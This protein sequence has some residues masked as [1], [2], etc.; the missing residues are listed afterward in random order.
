MRVQNGT[1]GMKTQTPGVLWMEMTEKSPK[2]GFAV[3]ALLL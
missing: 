1:Q 3:V 2:P